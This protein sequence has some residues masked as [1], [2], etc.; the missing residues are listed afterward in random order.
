M[1][2]AS[3]SGGLETKVLA[4]SIGTPSCVVVIML[5]TL[6]V[7]WCNLYWKRKRG[8]PEDSNRSANHTLHPINTDA[9]IAHRRLPDH[10]R[11]QSGD[12]TAH[13][14]GV[15]HIYQNPEEDHSLQEGMMNDLGNPSP[16]KFIFRPLHDL[17]YPAGEGIVQCQD[18]TANTK[19]EHYMDMSGTVKKK[20]ANGK[21]LQSMD[22]SETERDVDEN[23]YLISNVSLLGATNS[24]PPWSV[25]TANVCDENSVQSLSI[26][27]TA[28]GNAVRCGNIQGSIYDDILS[29]PDHSAPIREPEHGHRDKYCT[30]GRNDKYNDHHLATGLKDSQYSVSIYSSKRR[31]DPDVDE[32]G[33]L[34]LEAY[35]G[36]VVKDDRYVNMDKVQPTSTYLAIYEN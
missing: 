9:C 11:I 33:Y 15:Y 10:P 35:D 27:T 20:K 25:M 4:L 32:N 1:P 28:A 5:V 6:F 30:I 29:T 16:V 31:Q 13:Q 17:S 14:E 34:V 3:V 19:I 24:R 8:G 36:E 2:Y 22:T 7:T 23:G 21:F 12:A 26:H 18:T